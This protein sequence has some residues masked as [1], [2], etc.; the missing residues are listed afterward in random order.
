MWEVECR[1]LGPAAEVLGKE[2]RPDREL[3]KLGMAKVMGE[4]E[5]V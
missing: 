1:P 3:A 5:V 4:L 2:A